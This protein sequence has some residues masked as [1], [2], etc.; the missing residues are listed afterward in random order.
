MTDSTRSKDNS[1][2]G[3]SERRGVDDFTL[4]PKVLDSKIELYDS[5]S[6]LRSTIIKA[7][8]SW[9]RRRQ[10][11]LLSSV[12]S[13]VMDTSAIEEEHNKAFDL[14]D[15]ISRSGTLPIDCAEVHVVISLT[16]SFENDVM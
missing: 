2:E 3:K 12:A 15:A 8:R 11:N 4:I 10:H 13:S 7:S 14:L 5:D 6:S 16:H 9:T 1:I